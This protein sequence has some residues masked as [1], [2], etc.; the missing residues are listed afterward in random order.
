MIISINVTTKKEL[1]IPTVP[2]FLKSGK[3]TIRIKDIP[4]DELERIADAWKK[5]LLE[6]AN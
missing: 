6:K 2:N 5:N 3:E 1:E 4:Q